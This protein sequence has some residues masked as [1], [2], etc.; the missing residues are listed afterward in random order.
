MKR[1]LITAIIC[2]LL[3]LLGTLPAWAVST[4]EI[5]LYHDFAIGTNPYTTISEAVNGEAVLAHTFNFSS[6]IINI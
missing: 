1:I 2:G 6:Q 4:T 3:A 5:S